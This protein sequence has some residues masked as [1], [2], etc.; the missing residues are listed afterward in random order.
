MVQKEL[1]FEGGEKELMLLVKN[2]GICRFIFLYYDYK[3]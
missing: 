1:D 2:K 3:I